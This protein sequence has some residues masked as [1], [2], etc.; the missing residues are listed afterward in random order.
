M[1]NGFPLKGLPRND[2][3]SGSNSDISG[4]FQGFRLSPG[5]SVF[6]GGGG[7]RYTLGAW[8]SLYTSLEFLYGDYMLPATY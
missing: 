8:T 7:L 1:G 4:I 3:L 6:R 5:C 2:T